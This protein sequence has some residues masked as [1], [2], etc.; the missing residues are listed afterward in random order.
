MQVRRACMR[1]S[2]RSHKPDDVPTLDPHS[3][4]QPFHVPIQV[5]LIVAI[6]SHVIELVYCAAAPVAEEQFADRSGY[7]RMHGCP[8]GLQNVDRFMPMSVVNFFELSLLCSFNL[9]DVTPMPA[10]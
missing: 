5:C 3:L 9:G 10:V 1:I 4:P 7:H 8:F 6:H 2:R